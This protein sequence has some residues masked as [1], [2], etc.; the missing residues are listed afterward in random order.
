M[1]DDT[2]EGIATDEPKPLLSGPKR[3]HYLPRFYLEGFST[4][5]LVAVYDREKD[6]VRLQPPVNTAVIGH[7][8]TMID[9]EGRQRFEIEQMLAGVEGRASPVIAKLAGNQEITQGEREDLSMFIAL[10]AMRTPSIVDSIKAASSNMIGE[11]SKVMFSDAGRV[12]E[13]MRSI[14]MHEGASQEHLLSEAQ[15]QVEFVRS[16]SYEITTNHQ[17]AMSIAIRTAMD[18]APLFSVRNWYVLHPDKAAKSFVTTDSPVVLSR[19]R[20]SPSLYGVGYGSVDAE[21]YFPLTQ[22]CLLG[23]AG[24]DGRLVHQ[25]IDQDR[26]RNFNLTVASRCQ[27]FMV[28]RDGALVS[29][30]SSRLGLASKN[31]SPFFQRT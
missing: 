23:M 14:G 30:L 13:Q 28:G 15:K 21:V 10:G 26:V 16:G 25:K 20:S 9:A 7:F 27:R 18:L 1:Q 11:L 2:P 24:E 8:Y 5:G 29:S 17:F 19:K 31:W 6:E 3:Q 12:A 22:T 4:N